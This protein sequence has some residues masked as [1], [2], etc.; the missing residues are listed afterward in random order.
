MIEPRVL[1]ERAPDGAPVVGLERKVR[2]VA[3]QV[4]Q[5]SRL[6]AKLKTMEETIEMARLT[7]LSL[8]T[9]A[10][11]VFS[12]HPPT[13]THLYAPAGCPPH[14]AAAAR[15]VLN[16]PLLLGGFAVVSAGTDGPER[17]SDAQGCQDARLCATTLSA[18][19]CT[20]WRGGVA[21]V[22]APSRRWRLPALALA[23]GRARQ[24]SAASDRV[25]RRWALLAHGVGPRRF[26]GTNA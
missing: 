17:E 24:G 7:G 4:W 13:P 1:S 23:M 19:G 3:A 11:Q 18:Q 14:I 26:D 9:I 16:A 12:A 6:C 8:R 10:N 2:H 21:L 15:L 25:G 20:S 5:L 22:R